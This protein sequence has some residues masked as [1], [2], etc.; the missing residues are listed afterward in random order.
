VIGA[1]GRGQ[2]GWTATEAEVL[3]LLEPQH[4]AT[5]FRLDSID[6]LLAEHVWEYLSWEDGVEAA[7]NCFDFLKPGGYLRVAVPD[8]CHPSRDY[9]RLVEPNGT[10]PEGKTAKML[11]DYRSLRRLFE[12]AGFVVEMLEYFD[13]YGH[14]HYCDWNPADG[15]IH[16]SRLF[17]RRN[18]RGRLAYTSIILDAVKPAYLRPASVSAA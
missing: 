3:N 18:V 17:D 7:R 5:Y 12:A 15:V 2:D 11:F 4:W 13:E 10:G 14:F 6:A 8:G 16:R 1:G 9:L